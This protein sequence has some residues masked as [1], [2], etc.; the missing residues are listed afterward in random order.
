[1]K[2]FLLLLM[3]ALLCIGSATAW[4]I[5]S[6]QYSG[7]IEFYKDGTALAKVDGY[8][9]STFTWELTGKD[10]YEAHYWFYTVEFYHDQ[11]NDTITSA[12]FPNA[13][14]IR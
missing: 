1:M 6:D 8:P 4:Q 13:Y 7:T 5:H 14:M 12:R 2:R 3:A 10:T 11:I 9:T